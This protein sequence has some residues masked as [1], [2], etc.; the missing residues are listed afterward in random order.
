MVPGVGRGCRV[1]PPTSCSPFGL[2]AGFPAEAWFQ[3]LPLGLHLGTV[4]WAA[5][6]YIL[7]PLDTAAGV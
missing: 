6:P 3:R 2:L 4:W 5:S 1:S 7:W